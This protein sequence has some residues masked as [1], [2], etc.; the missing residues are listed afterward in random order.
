MSSLEELLVNPSVESWQQ[1]V[2]IGTSIK[3]GHQIIRGGFATFMKVLSEAVVV[4]PPE[5]ERICPKSWPEEFRAA[6]EHRVRETDT[7]S[8]YIAKICGHPDLKLSDGSQAVW[9]ER[10]FTGGALHVSTVQQALRALGRGDTTAARNILA[11]GIRQVGK[12]GC[13]DLTG[14][15]TVEGL[16]LCGGVDLVS[17]GYQGIHSGKSDIE[18]CDHRRRRHEYRLEVEIKVGDE[19]QRPEQ[20]ARMNSVRARGGCYI[21]ARSVEEAVQ[22]IKLF[23]CSH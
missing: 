16:D 14:G 11:G 13:A 18:R 2:E 10:R 23:I 21:L 1:I 17:T 22:Q 20:I 12:V 15:V 6:V 7:Y 9:L 5:I 19:E 4:W 3:R 8:H